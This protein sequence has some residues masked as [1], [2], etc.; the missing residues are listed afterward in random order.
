MASA[1]TASR[2]RAGAARV[3]ARGCGLAHRRGEANARPPDSIRLLR[4]N[5]MTASVPELAVSVK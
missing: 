4:C 2:R 1:D 5:S 3:A